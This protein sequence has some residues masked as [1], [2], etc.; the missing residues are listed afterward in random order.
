MLCDIRDLMSEPEAYA[1]ELRTR[2]GGRL[3]S[4]KAITAGAY[5]RVAAA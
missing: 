3:S 4:D 2:R 1:A 5:R